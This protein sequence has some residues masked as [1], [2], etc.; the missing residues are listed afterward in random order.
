MLLLLE[1]IEASKSDAGWV[2]RGVAG[3]GE[4]SSFFVLSLERAE[5]ELPGA[6][7]NIE[8]SFIVTVERW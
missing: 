2:E 5:G 7:I 4:G 6:E 3:F 1:K 8:N